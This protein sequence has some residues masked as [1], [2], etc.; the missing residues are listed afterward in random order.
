MAWKTGYTFLMFNLSLERSRQTESYHMGLRNQLYDSLMLLMMGTWHTCGFAF[1]LWSN[2]AG[3]VFYLTY[4]DLGDQ[5][6][7]SGRGT[8][9]CARMALPLQASRIRRLK[10]AALDRGIWRIALNVGENLTITWKIC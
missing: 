6:G 3:L 7:G 5:R 9:C 4:V 10:K 1:R 8:R 2:A